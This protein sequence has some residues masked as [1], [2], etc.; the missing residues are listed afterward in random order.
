MTPQLVLSNWPEPRT[1][2]GPALAR[3][4][5]RKRKP[6]PKQPWYAP[7]LLVQIEHITAGTLL[8]GDNTTDDPLTAADPSIPNPCNSGPGLCMVL[9]C[10]E[11]LIADK[12]A[13]GSVR[14]PLS[15][16]KTLT[17]PLRRTN[18]EA[19]RERHIED[20]STAVARR[21]EYLMEGWGSTCRRDVHVRTFVELAKVMQTT[22]QRAQQI[23][24]Q[25]QAKVKLECE[26]RGITWDGV[27]GNRTTYPEGP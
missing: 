23:A 11:N 27:T 16:T 1:M 21:A 20:A 13:A 6:R 18:R 25:A 26:R 3:R 2:R 8:P 22:R 17:V 14:I 24:D 10:R 4:L 15:N 5:P 7:L 9:S 12:T 19:I